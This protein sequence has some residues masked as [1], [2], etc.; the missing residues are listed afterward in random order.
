MGCP[1][2]PAV[3]IELPLA[4]P[5][6]K[7]ARVSTLIIVGLAATPP[8]DDR[9]GERT[10]SKHLRIG[11]AVALNLVLGR[12]S[13]NRAGPLFTGSC[14]A[15]KTH[16]IA[17]FDDITFPEQRCCERAGVMISWRSDEGSPAQDS[18]RWMTSLEIP[19]VRSSPSSGV[20]V[21]QYHDDEDDHRIIERHLAGSSFKAIRDEVNAT[22]SAPHGLRHPQIGLFPICHSENIATSR[23]SLTKTPLGPLY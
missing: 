11:S 13:H 14:G 6:L 23:V 7:P 5:L 21:R 1:L 4:W 20:R 15:R 2:E 10:S 3:Q 8:T 9:D 17:R 12:C 16:Y 22:S 18:R 19:A